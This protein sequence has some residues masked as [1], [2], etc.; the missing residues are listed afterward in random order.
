MYFKKFFVLDT[1][2]YLANCP[3]FLKHGLLLC[4]LN[5]FGRFAVKNFMQMS[6]ELAKELHD[7]SGLSN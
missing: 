1:F 5:L 6:G 7:D 4:Y 3:L 2:S